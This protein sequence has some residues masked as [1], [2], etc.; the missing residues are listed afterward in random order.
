MLNI[1]NK[2][3]QDNA[4]IHKCKVQD[5]N[6]NYPPPPHTNT[7]HTKTKI[8][9]SPR[10]LNAETLHGIASS[11]IAVNKG[12]VQSLVHVC[13]GLRFATLQLQSQMGCKLRNGTL[14][15]YTTTPIRLYHQGNADATQLSALGIICI[16]VAYFRLPSC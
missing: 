8:T 11:G 16:V 4:N 6:K 15:L 3:I 7:L 10:P 12:E 13:N 14:S 2:K 9:F 1:N 5:I